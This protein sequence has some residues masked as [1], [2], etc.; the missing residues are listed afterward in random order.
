MSLKI[1]PSKSYDPTLDPQDYQEGLTASSCI[2]HPPSSNDTEILVYLSDV[3]TCAEGLFPGCGIIIAGN[4][5]QLD[6][7]HLCRDFRLKNNLS[8]N[9]H[10]VLT[11]W[12]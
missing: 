4:F 11:I 5:N 3:I 2:Y 9:Q 12:I 8:T 1:P 7:K 10:A 6:T